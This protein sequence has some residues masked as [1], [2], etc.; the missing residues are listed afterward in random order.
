VTTASGKSRSGAAERPT[1]RD[2][3]V[4]AVL[5]AATELFAERGPEA[6]SIRDIA[7]HSGVNHGLV[8]RHFGT[9]EQLIGAVLDH[10]SSQVAEQYDGRSPSAA[11]GTTIDQHLQVIARAILDGYPA[12]QLQRRFPYINELVDEAR[13]HHPDETA[14]RIAAANA[15]ALQLGWRLFEPFLRSAAGLQRLSATSLRDAIHSATASQI[16]SGP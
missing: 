12:G 14:A 11:L 15:V 16:G 3:V 13:Q 2:E 9:K 7:K 4:D 1:G 8:F 5:A 10:L 6:T